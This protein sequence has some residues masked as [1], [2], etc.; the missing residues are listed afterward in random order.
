MIKGIHYY[1]GLTLAVFVGLHLLNHLMVLHSE[2]LHI[3][4]MRVARKIYRQPVIEGVL[5]LAVALQIFTGTSLVIRKWP[6]AES[7]Y[8]WAHIGSGIYLALFLINHVKAAI[9][10]RRKLHIDTDLYYGAG[11]MNMWPHKL[12]YIPY[13]ALAILSFFIHVACIHREKMLQFV[14]LVSAEIQ[15]SGIMAMG[16]VVTFLVIYRMSRLKMPAGLTKSG[17]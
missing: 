16:C 7:W 14:S 17:G 1:S 8:D 2:T 15:S 11:V 4:F 13:Y 6:G 9:T 5:L 3:N 12:F 10:G